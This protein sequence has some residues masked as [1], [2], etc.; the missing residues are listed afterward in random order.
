MNQVQQTQ[1]PSSL[2]PPAFMIG[3]DRHGNWVVQDRQGKCGGLFVDREAALRYVRAENGYR[4]CAVVMVSGNLELDMGCASRMSHHEAA[5][6]LQ[7]QRRI[8]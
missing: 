6:D 3:R 5:V 4:P 2:R 7:R 8:A 1:P